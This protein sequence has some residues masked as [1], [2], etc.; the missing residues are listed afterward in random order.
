MTE[1]EG[2]VTLLSYFLMDLIYEY[3]VTFNDIMATFQVTHSTNFAIP[4]LLHVLL[5]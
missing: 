1:I 4:H 2:N 5:R 3:N